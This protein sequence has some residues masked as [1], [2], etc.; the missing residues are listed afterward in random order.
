MSKRRKI[1]LILAIVLSLAVF[2]QNMLAI[3][4]VL[5]DDGGYDE[6][7]DG[8]MYADYDDDDD[9]GGDDGYDEEE[10]RKEQERQEALEKAAE[11]NR[12]AQEQQ[13]Q[14]EAAR[15]AQELAEQKEKEAQEAAKAS[16]AKAT[17]IYKLTANPSSLN[18]GE[19]S[20]GE[21]RDVYSVDVVNAG[22]GEV[23]FTFY[24][25]NKTGA[26]T[27]SL[28]SGQIVGN[29]YHLAKNGTATFSVSMKNTLKA[30]TYKD[31]L[32]FKIADPEA[33][34]SS[35]KVALS[36]SVTSGDMKQI[37]SVVVSPQNY[38]LSVGDSYQF[39]ATVKDDDGNEKGVNQDVTW[40]VRGAR[41]AGTDIS[42][43][44]V[45]SIAGDESS[46]GLKIL[47]FSV[48]KP[49]VYGTSSVTPQRSGYNI[50][51]AADPKNGGSVTGGG[52]VVQGGSVTITAIPNSNYSF[53][54]WYEDGDKV[55]SS[56]NY[57]VYDV[58]T[59]MGFVAKFER[60]YVTV[61]L[62]RNDSDGGKVSGGGKIRY[63]ESTTI[64]AK[65]NSG[66]VFTGWKEDGDIISKDASY[67]LKNLK[68]DRKIKAMFERT[69]HTLTVTARPSEG[70]KV[71]GGGTFAI[72][73]GTTLKAVPNSGYTFV[74]WE[75][76]GQIV[77]R[78]ATV[79]INR[80][81]EDY[82]CTA[83]FL[84]TGISTF[85]ISAGVATTG[86]SI[87]PSGKSVVAQGQ[88]IT[89]T[90]TPKSGFAVLAVA[91][92]GAQ[93]GPVTTYT[94]SNVQGN[95]TI[96]AAFLLTDAGKANAA[97]NG[98]ETQ[99][100]K[101]KK[102]E[103][104]EANTAKTDST[105]K[106]E[107]ALS[108]EGGDDYV[109]E[110]EDLDSIAVPTDEELGVA[111]EEE[112]E[113]SEVA[114]MLGVSVT[115]ARAMAENGQKDA[116]AR[117]A[118]YAGALE[119]NAV[120]QLEPV[121]MN[122]VDYSTL[123]TEELMQLPDDNIYP[124][125]KNLDLVVENM[126]TTDDMIMLVDGGS[127]NISVSLT[128]MGEHDIAPAEEKIMK[129][130]V[131]QKPLMYFDLSMLKTSNGYTE[132]VHDL[133]DS[134]EIVVEIP[135]DIYKAG[136]TYSVLRVHEGELKVLP[137]LDDD[138]KTITFRTDR[139]SSYAIA[140]QT[141]SSRELVLYLMLGALIALL[142][143]LTCF[144]ILIIHQAKMRKARRRVRAEQRRR[145]REF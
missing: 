94:F 80:L 8:P 7:S 72:N 90:I 95:H 77:N 57:T 131:G 52:S 116:I 108:G 120:N 107:D 121:N 128:K 141:A 11:E 29:T 40:E 71:S 9:D 135:D 93:I 113:Y 101:V 65:A 84:K 97:K 36:G 140:M 105:V 78:D 109:E 138:P 117:A 37:K 10:I 92:D 4:V 66:Y 115:E 31:A 132:N 130:A 53:K 91:V 14:D 26:F 139:F 133:G 114:E 75:V 54:G 64:T 15:A 143:A 125:Y 49:S 112:S 76:N 88:N 46:T 23:D 142:V 87:S 69:S 126:L 63:G 39:T 103:K 13:E 2:A 62:D 51:V 82:K 96:A 99:A 89:Y 102:V 85:E 3:R 32:V 22:T 42:S 19:E 104:T 55:S 41:S 74:G 38:R 100:E 145:E 1:S 129:N 21:D 86:G 5:A 98:N 47:A 45:L 24:Y 119:A 18:F 35:V 67:K 81:E 25:A 83:V 58:Y 17:V 122:G 43:S 33:D 56:T 27:C 34:G 68:E 137:D 60:K 127:Q 136:K 48:E 123:S 70:G 44:G 50:S 12:R 30:G 59:S 106:I 16:E 79:K 134:M 28:V 110:M 111:E 73:Q 124:S 61:D 20:V 118:F 144:L 6:V